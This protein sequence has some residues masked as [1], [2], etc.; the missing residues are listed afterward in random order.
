MTIFSS[1]VSLPEGTVYISCLLI[2]SLG[3]TPKTSLRLTGLESLVGKNQM[4]P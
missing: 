3:K 4:T 1:Y 2:V